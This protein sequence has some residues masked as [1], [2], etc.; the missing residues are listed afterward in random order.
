MAVKKGKYT[1]VM[2]RL[3]TDTVARLRARS[4]GNESLYRQA[5]AIIDSAAAGRLVDCELT[6]EEFT[7]LDMLARRIGFAGTPEL[8]KQLVLAYLR[9]FRR[10]NEFD[11]EVVRDEVAE[12]FEEM[13]IETNARRYEEGTVTTT[14]PRKIRNV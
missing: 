2:L 3:P 6:D 10:N 12:L 11:N 9:L 8:M 7:E 14:T 5:R 1:A 4:R 13:D